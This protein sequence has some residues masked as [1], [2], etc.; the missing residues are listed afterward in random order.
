MLVIYAK[1]VIEMF[2]MEGL[3]L[4]E[5]AWKYTEQICETQ[6]QKMLKYHKRIQTKF[7]N[8]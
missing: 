1:W 2:R 6:F 4:D 7:A 5:I 8:F 3:T